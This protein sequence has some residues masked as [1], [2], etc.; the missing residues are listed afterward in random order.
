M[1]KPW[2]IVLHL[3]GITVVHREDDEHTDQPRMIRTELKIQYVA[4]LMHVNNH[5]MVDEVTICSS[6][7]DW[8]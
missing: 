3:S 7:R 6:S 8:P 4:S 5:Q 1:M 2:A